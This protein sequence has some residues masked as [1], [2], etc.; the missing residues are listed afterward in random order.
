MSTWVCACV[1]ES[2]S[3]KPPVSRCAAW[4]ATPVRAVVSRTV[5][6]ARADGAGRRTADQVDVANNPLPHK[7][8][9]ARRRALHQPDELVADRA[10]EAHV[11]LEDLEV[12]VAHPGDEYAHE[13]LARKRRRHRHLAQRARRAVHHEGLLLR[14]WTDSRWRRESRRAADSNVFWTDGIKDGL[15]T[16]LTA[17]KIK[18]L[19]LR[20][21]L[22]AGALCHEEV[23]W[24]PSRNA[25]DRFL[26]QFAGGR[27]AA[28]A[29]TRT[30]RHTP[31]PPPSSQTP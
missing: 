2:A 4:G 28:A 18:A 7:R 3:R 9:P 20:D 15:R 12:G 6:A 29:P 5:A 14:H 30:T 22:L 11:A 19:L 16:A 10:A 17:N 1:R 13:R 27:S 26:P 25:V 31:R 24:L 21:S 8:L 23:V